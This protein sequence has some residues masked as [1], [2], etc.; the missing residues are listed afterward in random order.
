MLLE[1]VKLIT[2]LQWFYAFDIK[3]NGT[4]FLD[5]ATANGIFWSIDFYAKTLL[6]GSLEK[7]EISNRFQF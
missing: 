3:L 1:F 2:F 5:V 6:E 4:H 7:L